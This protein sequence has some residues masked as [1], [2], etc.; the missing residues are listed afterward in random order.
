[1]PEESFSNLQILVLSGQLLSHCF[2]LF[3]FNAEP[4][5]SLLPLLLQLFTGKQCKQVLGHNVE[6]RPLASP[7]REPRA[8]QGLD[9]WLVSCKNVAFNTGVCVRARV[10]GDQVGSCCLKIFTTCDAGFK[11]KVCC[12]FKDEEAAVADPAGV[13]VTTLKKPLQP[14]QV[15]TP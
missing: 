8:S 12:F 10:R 3:T 14:S 5:K 4:S 13:A 11:T 2:F 6:L 7:C 15:R 9:S 1:M